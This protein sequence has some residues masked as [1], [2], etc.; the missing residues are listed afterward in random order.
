M[1]VPQLPNF[2]KK[3]FP[4]VPWLARFYDLLRPW[5][6]GVSSSLASSPSW[7][8]IA[9]GL[10]VT[11]GT[12]GIL[13]SPPFVATTVVPGALIATCE[14]L[15]NGRGVGAYG[16]VTVSWRPSSSGGQPGVKL[17]RLHAAFPGTYRLTVWALSE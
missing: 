17:E 4:D 3:A 10:P 1:N 5:L 2:D 9:E 15:V 12:D 7:V 16:S 13:A 8:K 11:A 6:E 14:P